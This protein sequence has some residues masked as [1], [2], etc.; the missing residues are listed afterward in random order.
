MSGIGLDQRG[1]DLLYSQVNTKR[2]YDRMMELLDDLSARGLS[3][4]LDATFGKLDLRTKLSNW[5]VKKN[6]FLK[7]V[8]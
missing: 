7:F 5:S 8:Q 1:D 4:V 3:L 2:T 6:V